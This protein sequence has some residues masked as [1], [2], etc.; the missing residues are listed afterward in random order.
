M[1]Y[2]Q[3][4]SKSKQL[5]IKRLFRAIHRGFM[6]KHANHF[7]YFSN[8]L[9]YIVDRDFNNLDLVPAK[10]YPINPKTIGEHIRK[11]NGFWVNAKRSCKDY[12]SD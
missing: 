3:G 1:I 6:D 7:T 5:K 11:K 12:W 9:I 10:D 8:L 2:G 4:Y